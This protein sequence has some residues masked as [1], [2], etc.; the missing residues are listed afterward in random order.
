M[1]L[2]L[3]DRQLIIVVSDDE[4]QSAERPPAESSKGKA[5]QNLLIPTVVGAPGVAVPLVAAGVAGLVGA[6][7]SFAVQQLRDTR[8]RRENA[9]LPYLVVT[10]GQA[11]S[12]NFPFN[13]PRPNVVYVADPGIGGNYYPIADFHRLLFDAKVAEA[14]RLLGSLAATQISVEYI[15]G[16]DRGAGIDLSVSPETGEVFNGGVG[17]SGTDKRRS[18]AK[19]TME[20]FPTTAPRIPDDLRWFRSEP[21]WQEIARLRLESGLRTFDLDLSYT[22]DFGIN[23]SLKAKFAGA[24]FDL[25]GTFTEYRETQWRISGSFAEQ[26]PEAGAL[27]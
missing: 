20:L 21:L 8:E 16:F 9:P 26:R 23:A 5:S 22:D 11:R 2:P 3:S 10:N 14:L 15:K 12:L 1:T 13:H 19:A 4:V 27:D 17:T 7:L 25:G 24:G 18:G 6:A